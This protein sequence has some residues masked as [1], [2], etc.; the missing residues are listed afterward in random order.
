MDPRHDLNMLE[1]IAQN[2]HCLK[3]T[4][5]G[6]RCN[7]VMTSWGMWRGI[8]FVH[9]QDQFGREYIISDPFPPDDAPLERFKRWMKKT[10]GKLTNKAPEPV[11]EYKNM[12]TL[13]KIHVQFESLF[14]D[15]EK[16][17]V[18]DEHRAERNMS[19][20]QQDFF[21]QLRGLKK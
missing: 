20:V 13:E 4:E 10:W 17:Q 15:A 7:D 21:D 8:R 9:F 14:N 16:R 1:W 2:R 19:K 12:T 18:S 11:K 5:E 3:A 6:L